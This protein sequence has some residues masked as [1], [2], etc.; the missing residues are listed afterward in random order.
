VRETIKEATLNMEKHLYITSRR[1]FH[2]PHHI[3][4]AIFST[5]IKSLMIYHFSPLFEVGYISAEKID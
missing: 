2:L 3:K 5:Q 1:D 4:K